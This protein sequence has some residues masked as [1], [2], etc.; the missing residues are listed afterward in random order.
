MMEAMFR[1]ET[2]LKFMGLVKAMSS[3]LRD[4]Q[5]DRSYSAIWERSRGDIQCKMRVSPAGR[6]TR[7]EEQLVQARVRA[8][9]LAH[10]VAIVVPEGRIV[11]DDLQI[12]ERIRPRREAQ[13]PDE[14]E[15]ALVEADEE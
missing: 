11:V 8:S 2:W 10:H 1:T 4:A 7:P 5:A 9:Q 3:M 15:R 14:L 12:T 6:H 13:H